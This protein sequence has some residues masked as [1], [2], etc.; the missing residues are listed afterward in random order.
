[1]EH[2]QLLFLIGSICGVIS[3][4]VL[5]ILYI[6]R[7]IRIVKSFAAQFC[8]LIKE[9]YMLFRQTQYWRKHHPIYEIVECK[10]L[11]IRHTNGNYQLQIT[12]ELEYISREKEYDTVFQYGALLLDIRNKGTGIEGI[13]YR[14]I[15]RE[16]SQWILSPSPRVR[17]TYLFKCERKGEPQL[18]NSTHCKLLSAGEVRLELFGKSRP[19]K[20]FKRIISVSHI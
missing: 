10:P 3:A 12:I 6:V 2:L 17:K 9:K 16:P 20:G 7:L 18:G 13:P 4:I 1:M 11:Q 19:L 15:A 5:T 8:S 14:L